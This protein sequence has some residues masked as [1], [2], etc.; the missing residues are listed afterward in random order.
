MKSDMPLI[1]LVGM[2]LA[3]GQRRLQTLKNQKGSRCVLQQQ[4][5][6]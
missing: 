2:A 1:E 4:S 6:N 5:K 3:I